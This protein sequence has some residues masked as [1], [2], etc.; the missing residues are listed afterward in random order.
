MIETTHQWLAR[1]ENESAHLASLN[2]RLSDPDKRLDYDGF[3]LANCDAHCRLIIRGIES[4][5][6]SA[7]RPTTIAKNLLRTLLHRGTYGAFAEIAAYEWLARCHMSYIPQVLLT[8]TEVLSKKGSVIDGKMFTALIL[9]SK[10]SDSLVVSL[11][12]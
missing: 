7:N 4:V 12:F 9:M 8:S 3:N 10:H 11:I 1:L 6:N 2:C 5:L